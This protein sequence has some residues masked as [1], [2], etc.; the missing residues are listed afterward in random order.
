VL[1]VTPSDRLTGYR[2]KAQIPVKEENGD[3]KIG[4]YA[5]NSHRVIENPNC[6]IQIA[7]S[8]DIIKA[9]KLYMQANGIKAWNEE[10]NSGLI[11]H[12]LIRNG[13]NTGDVMVCLVI[14]AKSGF[15]PFN[16]SELIE[17][18]SL[19]QGMKSI[20]LNY[21]TRNDN[22]I[23]GDKCKTI[24]GS[25]YITDT[26]NGFTF[27]ISPLSFYQV[28]PIQALKMYEKAV[29]LS[30]VTKDDV[31][32]DAYSGIGTIASFMALRAKKV[33]GIEIIPQA[34]SDAMVN[35]E[36]NGL[37]NVCFTTGKSEEVIFNLSE[38]GIRPDII[39]L[40]PPRKGCEAPVIEA[41][42]ETAPRAVVYIS[43][44]PD[45]LARDAKALRD[46][47]YRL[48]ELHPYDMFVHSVHVESVALF[49]RG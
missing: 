46:G 8:A 33:Y 38:N 16:I 22:V 5:K 30:K 28:N 2:N 1:P 32:V 13:V 29:E 4:Y 44:N 18:L 14:N 41:I 24:W 19:I 31:V 23:M 47:G 48:I 40:D 11:R 21:N 27:R 45:T 20:S 34:V 37:S 9:L 35:A 6:D 25:E 12:L 10:T 43:C 42:I 36:I 39:V 26:M 3:I 49:E 17:D 15:I 7:V